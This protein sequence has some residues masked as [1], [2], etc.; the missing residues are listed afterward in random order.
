MDF[1]FALD[2]GL[3]LELWIGMTRTYEMN[4]ARYQNIT[5][6]LFVKCNWLVDST[7]ENKGATKIYL[8]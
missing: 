4:K 3:S 1:C 7:F 6:S 5:P 2:L 8:Y